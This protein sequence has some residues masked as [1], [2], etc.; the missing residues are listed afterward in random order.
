M[1]LFADASYWIALLSRRDSLHEQALSAERRFAGSS[2]VTTEMV[3][4]EVANGVAASGP[5][6]RTIVAMA[7]RSLRVTARVTILP[8]TSQQFSEALTLYEKVSDKG[9]SLTDCASLMTMNQ[10][11]LQLALTSDHHFVQAGYIALLR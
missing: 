10:R 9:W 7:L 6:L 8:Q 4:A 11:G 1:E 5:H 3:L 2:I